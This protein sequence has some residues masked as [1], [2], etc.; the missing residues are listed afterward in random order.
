MP[1]PRFARG[2]PAQRPRPHDR[3]QGH[4]AVA[5]VPAHQR[6][7]ARAVAD[8]PVQA[9]PAAQDQGHWAIDGEEARRQCHARTLGVSEVLDEEV[10]APSALL[11][12]APFEVREE[13]FD[14]H[15]PT[16]PHDGAQ[17]QNIN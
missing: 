4:E 11:G 12:E 2:D 7:C 6:P 10:D 17:N 3:P 13:E 1:T 15:A 8:D 16:V 9:P 14:V 5:A